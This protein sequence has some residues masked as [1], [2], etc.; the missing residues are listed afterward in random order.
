MYIMSNKKNDHAI[1]EYIQ[2]SMI[3]ISNWQFGET[4]IIILVIAE[5]IDQA[6]RIEK[7]S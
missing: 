7:K 6:V 3:W 2:S 5:R 4:F 1:L